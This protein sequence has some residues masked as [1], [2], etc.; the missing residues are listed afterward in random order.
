MV[1]RLL[2]AAGAFVIFCGRTETEGRALESELKGKGRTCE[3]IRADV[4]AEGEVWALLDTVG[5]QFGCLDVL[6]NNAGITFAATAEETSLQDWQAIMAINL[7]SVFLVSKA[8]VPLLRCSSR[9][10][11][12]NVASTYGVVGAPGNAAYAASKAGVI[13]LTAT[14]A[15][16]LAGQHIRVNAICPG[17]TA[18]PMNAEW[19]AA[20]PDPGQAMADL[21]ADHP[22]G[23]ISTPEEQ[24][25]AILFLASPDASYVT[26]H[27]LVVDGG[28]TAR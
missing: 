24:A 28:R 23:R 9:A 3:F 6:V 12:V 13:N 21:V 27:A 7:T 5:A 18:T 14:M 16:E 26:G 2:A 22:I 8:A 17:A 19:L 10:A 15:L 1:V 20:Q 11:I 4:S 25:H